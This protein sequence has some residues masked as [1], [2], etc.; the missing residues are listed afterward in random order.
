MLFNFI[1]DATSING[2]RY[3]INGCNM[4]LNIQNKNFQM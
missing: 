3:I 1:Y 2:Y 4:I